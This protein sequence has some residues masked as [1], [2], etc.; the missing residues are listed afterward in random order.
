MKRFFSRFTAMFVALLVLLVTGQSLAWDYVLCLGVD[1]HSAFEEA[2][3]GKCG[4]AK[5]SGAAQD[6]L[7]FTSD[8]CGSCQ[9]LS[10][11]FD[12]LHR[13]SGGDQDLSDSAPP[14]GLAAATSPAIPVFI[15]DLTTNL[16]PPPPPQ[17]Y[18]ALI[19][20]RTVVLLN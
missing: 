16:S 19:A 6:E 14:P 12:S 13:R 15:R 5:P 1:G 17:S 9:D 2:V 4:P 10:P 3:A 18:H 20:L 7:S 8:H 11:S